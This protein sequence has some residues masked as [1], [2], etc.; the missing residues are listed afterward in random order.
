[1]K[2]E[3]STKKALAVYTPPIVVVFAIMLAV[4]IAASTFWQDISLWLY[5]RAQTT[6]ASVLQSGT[7]L[8]VDIVEEGIVLLKNE[9]D[10]KGKAALPLTKEEI[11]KVNVFGWAA[12]DW[13]TMAFGSGYSNTKLA[14]VKLF[15]ALKEAGIEY[16]EDLYNLYR[17]FYSDSSNVYNKQEDEQEYRGGVS[18]GSEKIFTLHEPGASF[19]TDTLKNSIIAH[20]GV[21]LVVI[22]R[23]GS[24]S[25][26]LKLNQVKQ[27]QQNKSTV[28]TTVTDRHYLE[29]STEEEEMIAVAKETCEK[30]IVILNTAN[31]METGFIDD[32]DIDAALLVGITGLTGVN[33]LINVLRGEKI[34]K[35][36]ERD[37]NGNVIYDENGDPVYKKNENGEIVTETVKVSPSGRTVDTY[38][39]DVFTAPSMANYGAESNDGAINTYPNARG[40]GDRYNSYIDYSEGIYVGYKWYETADAEGYWD[41]VDNDYGKG[42]EGVV[43]FPFG[44]G[45]SYTEFT[46]TVTNVLINGQTKTSGELG[47]NDKIEIYIEVKNVGDY[48]GKDVIELYYTPPYIKGGIEKAH[49]NLGAFAKTGVIAPGGTDIVK[50]ELSVQSMASY[51]CYDMNGNNHTGYELDAG[52]YQIR[53]MKNAHENAVL[54]D[55]AFNGTA[56]AVKDS[57]ITYTVP[58]GGYKYDTDEKTGNKVENRFTNK[59]GFGNDEVIDN[60][61]LD[62]SRESEPVKY[63]SRGDIAGT[64]PTKKPARART[65]EAGSVAHNARP[66]QAQLDYAGYG[67]ITSMP[68]VENNGLVFNDAVGTKSY[69]DEIWAQLIAQ[70]PADEL[71]TLVSDGYFKTARLPSI[72]KGETVDLDGPLGFNTRVT[73]GSALCEFVAYPSATTL[74]QTW[75]VE[76][77]H[78]YGLSIGREAKSMNGLKGWYAPGANIHRNPFGGR[79]G[80]YYS[81]DGYLSGMICAG[82]VQGAKEMG[83]YSYVKHFVVNDSEKSREGLFTFLTEQTLREVYLKPFEL[84]IKEGGGNALMTSMNRLGRVW[85]GANY[86]LMTEIVRNEW[87][88]RGAAVTDWVNAGE[89]YMPPYLGIWAGNDT[90]LSNGIGTTFNVLKGNAAATVMGQKVAHDVLW[91]IVDCDNAAAAYDPNAVP[92][93][94]SAGATYNMTWVWYIVLIEIVLAAGLGVMAF[95]LTKTILKNKKKKAAASDGTDSSGPNEAVDAENTVTAEHDETSS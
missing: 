59:D 92:T 35:V 1:M 69:D 95:F 76:L 57:V 68:V 39:Y 37:E 77:A 43:Q 81:E 48:P 79:N 38:A 64:L 5:G 30:V 15:P 9:K 20:S 80:E 82:T 23:T 89:D 22:G 51:D 10:S 18:F 86:G 74:A 34:E 63:L 85:A 54:G 83:V 58:A 32:P 29:L 42:Y 33:G 67:N 6:D 94:F 71:V 44:Y 3:M 31:T 90:W 16:N 62:G 70:I 78:A 11:A 75:N 4:I 17:N 91:M 56:A 28:N 19:Y 72:S 73:S 41:D 45:L 12:Y 87:G 50:L 21:A 26:D 24:E 66:S 47:K 25:K 84:M 53:L 49:V 55:T 88:F 93:D 14:K 65:E 8:C 60:N 27:T 36:A 61:D 46:W 2:K 13:M 52:P 7:E 40:E